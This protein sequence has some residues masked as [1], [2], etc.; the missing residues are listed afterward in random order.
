M[1]LARTISWDMTLLGFAS[2]VESILSG[3]NPI[4]KFHI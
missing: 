1:K 4:R 3:I 2:R